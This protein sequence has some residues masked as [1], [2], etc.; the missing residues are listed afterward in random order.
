M[1]KDIKLAGPDLTPRT[2]KSDVTYKL[3]EQVGRLAPIA[4]Q[5]QLQTYKIHP[6][7]NAFS[8]CYSGTHIRIHPDARVRVLHMDSP[9]MNHDRRL[10][11][12]QILISNENK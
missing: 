2:L 7:N 5:S 11:D 4:A 1:N 12:T 8:T 6:E 3:T 10:E 9:P